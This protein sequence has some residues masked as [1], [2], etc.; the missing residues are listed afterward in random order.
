LP[1]EGPKW[2]DSG[3]WV[4]KALEPEIWK[5]KA[6]FANLG[7]DPRPSPDLNYF[8]PPV[9]QA[10]GVVIIPGTRFPNFPLTGPG[11]L[12]PENGFPGHQERP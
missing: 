3:P 12:I 8:K 7:R 5:P 4:G 10:Q 11:W 2:L 1:L 9:C 6:F